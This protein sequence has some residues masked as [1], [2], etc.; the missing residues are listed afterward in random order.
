VLHLTSFTVDGSQYREDVLPDY[1]NLVELSYDVKEIH[2]E[3]AA[4]DW[5]HPSRTKYF[6][7]IEGISVTDEWIENNEATIILTGMKPGKYVLRLYAVNGDGIKSN[8][9]KLPI[10]MQA[11]FWQRWWF[12][13][14]VVL[15]IIFLGYAIYRYRIG[16]I[17][18]LQS[19]RNTI[20]TNL[21]DD[22][23][24]SLSNIH[25]LNVLTQR[26]IS[27]KESATSYITKAGDEIQRISEALSDI[28]WNINPK[29]DDLDNLFIR[30]KR[31]AAD[32]LDGKNI[33][34]TLVFPEH[35]DKV[36]MPMDQRRD[37]YLIFK[38]AVNNLVKYAEAS[39]A[40]VQVVIDHRN[41]H[42]EVSDNGKGF[43]EN[44]II[45]GNGIQNMKQRAEKWNADLIVRS[46][47][48]KGTMI[49]LEMKVN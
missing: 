43:D 4:M 12:I 33:K 32:M 31:Y 46:S 1:F 40:T 18:K 30:M 47:P 28:V 23:G 17:K 3:Y 42:L 20:S 9:I 24:A 7:R 8:E 35:V 45:P 21:H 19:M 10:L 36:S 48:G 34:A 2:I 25:I 39:A 49:S 26:N 5:L 14:L 38:E 11:P 16:Q 29:Y 15:S 44:I 37:F 6:Y 41:I 13:V 22:I 27:N